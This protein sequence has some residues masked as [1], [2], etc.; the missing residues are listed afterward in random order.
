MCRV[1][2]PEIRHKTAISTIKSTA[3]KAA[4]RERTNKLKSEDMKKKNAVKK[5]TSRGNPSLN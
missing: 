4:S 5:E 1:A 2:L 3:E